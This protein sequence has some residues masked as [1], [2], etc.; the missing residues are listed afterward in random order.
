ML[1]ADPIVYIVVVKKLELIESNHSNKNLIIYNVLEYI[2]QNN[3]IDFGRRA[4]YLVVLKMD[5][6]E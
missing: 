5:F 2:N 6:F 4:N 3:L 1:V